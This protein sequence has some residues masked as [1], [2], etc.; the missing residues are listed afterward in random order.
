MMCNRYQKTA[1]NENVISYIGV[2]DFCRG[3]MRCLKAFLLSVEAQSE[4]KIEDSVAELKAHQVR[5]LLRKDC[6]EPK[7]QKQDICGVEVT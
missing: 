3:S 1:Q 7:A 4:S 6:G 2:L 5:E